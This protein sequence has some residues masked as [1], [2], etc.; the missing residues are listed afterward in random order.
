M[1]NERRL[2]PTDLPEGYPELLENL[3]SRIQTSRVR[4]ALSVNRELVNLYW[5]IGKTIV[6]RQ[7]EEGWGKSVI[8]RLAADIRKAFPG[9][10]GFSPRNVWNMRRLYIEYEENEK[11]QQLVAEIPWGHNLVLINK[12][13]SE[14]EREF[15]MRKTLENGWSRAVLTVQIESGLYL[16]QG[17]AVT[18]FEARLPPQQSDLTQQ[19]VKD[20]Y[21]FDFLAMAD[22][23]HERQ[24]E[25]KLID[26]IQDFLLE[27]GVG[28]AFVGRQV[29]LEVGGQDFYIDLL[30][31]HLR[32]R[33]FVIIDLKMKKFKPEYAGK[34]N[35]YLSAVDDMMRHPDDRQS[36]G[37]ILCRDKNRFVADYALR[38]MNKPIGVTGWETRLTK[39]LPAELEENLP[40]V[41]EIEDELRNDRIGKNNSA[42]A[43]GRNS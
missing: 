9:I 37:L 28:F 6:E 21:V 25:R 3:K 4:A 7:R 39:S 22:D 31:Y 27:L 30:F 16:R 26:H 15:Y 11:L 35:F 42:A 36:V 32:L 34:M 14:K 18:N 5:Q 40:T 20:P 12:L 23:A 1:G 29:H 43:C 41:A 24:V 33:C 19:A 38:G 8:E 17:Q 13:G 10:M 2:S